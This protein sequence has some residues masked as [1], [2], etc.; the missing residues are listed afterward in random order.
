MLRKKVN[1]INHQSTFK[2][3][4]KD[5]AGYCVYD[6]HFSVIQLD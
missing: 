6:E 3:K 2:H 1:L 4:N 5:I